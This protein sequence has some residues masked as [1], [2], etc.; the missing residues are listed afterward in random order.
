VGDLVTEPRRIRRVHPTPDEARAVHLIVA[1]DG[2]IFRC[3]L[4]QIGKSR[5]EWRWIFTRM[6]VGEYIGPPFMEVS[7]LEL[8]AIVDEWWRERRGL[9]SGQAVQ[10]YRAWLY[11]DMAQDN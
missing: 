7:L 8:Y 9:T 1:E 10:E 5:R 2:T 3:T 4:R 6:L 11:R